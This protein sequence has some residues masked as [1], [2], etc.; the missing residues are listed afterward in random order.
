MDI[1]QS[2][3]WMDLKKATF[4]SNDRISGPAIEKRLIKR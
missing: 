3:D 4:L 1:D 2:M